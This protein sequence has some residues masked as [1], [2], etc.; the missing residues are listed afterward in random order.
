[1]LNAVGGQTCTTLAV[2]SRERAAMIP[3]CW[4]VLVI[5]GTQPA[6]DVGG[7]QS[8]VVSI[9]YTPGLSYCGDKRCDGPG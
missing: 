3:H 4:G 9:A 1:M 8:P 5:A 2:D 7:F 6:P